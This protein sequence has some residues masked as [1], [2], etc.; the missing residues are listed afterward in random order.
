MKFVMLK[1]ML[2]ASLPTLSPIVAWVKTEGGNA[3]T[4][5]LIAFAVYFL[6]K[7][8]IG[9]FIGFIIFS[10]IV[11]LAIGNPTSIIN[12]LKAIWETMI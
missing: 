9:E 11:F 10:A 5:I 4:I 12:A 3:A 2:G 6:F 1:M 7:K 8:R